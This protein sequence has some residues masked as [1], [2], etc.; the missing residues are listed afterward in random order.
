MGV[1]ILFI[2]NFHI[3]MNSKL[4]SSSP[5][6]CVY[7]IDSELWLRVRCYFILI[8]FFFLLY[9]YLFFEFF[10]SNFIKMQNH[11][12]IHYTFHSSKSLLLLL[13][14]DFNYR[15]SYFIDWHWQLYKIC[16]Y[17]W[18]RFNKFLECVRMLIHLFPKRVEHVR[19]FFSHLV[20][21]S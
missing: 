10:Y 13:L 4:M 15:K 3:I 20:F 19:L 11:L 12:F 5:V 2:I 16:K 21:L 6:Y 14:N 9:F 18:I 7:L 1:L 17:M 8:F